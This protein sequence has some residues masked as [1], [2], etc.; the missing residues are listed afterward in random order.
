MKKRA[1]LA[2][3]S[4]VDDAVESLRTIIHKVHQLVVFRGVLRDPVVAP[5]LD[6]LDGI[7]GDRLHSTKVVRRV[8]WSYS[9]FFVGLAAQAGSGREMAV[10][11]PWQDHLLNVILRDENPFSRGSE[12]HGLNCLG[13]SLI[14]QV[15][16]DLERLRALFSLR[17]EQVQ[18]L[19]QAIGWDTHWPNWDRLQQRETSPGEILTHRLQIKRRLQEASD[20]EPLVPELATFYAQNGTGMFAEFRAFHWKPGSSAGVLQ[21]IS[22]PDPIRMEDLVGYE[23]QKLW[24]IRNTS[25]FLAGHPANNIFLYGDRGTGKSSSIKALLNHFTNRRLRMVEVSRDDLNDLPE[26][27][28]LLRERQQ[29]FI[30]F[31]DDLSFEEGETQYKTLKAVLEGSLESRPQNVVVYATSN[32]RHLIREFFSDRNDLRGDEIRHQDTLQEKVS[33]A[34]RFGIQLSFV[35]PDQKQYLEII[36]SMSR[37]RG[38]TLSPRDL[39]RRALEW[40][41]LYNARSGRTARQ[42]TDCLCAELET[43]TEEDRPQ[44]SGPR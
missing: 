23:D 30:L 20:W 2:L 15:E 39:E 32:R 1:G 29:H 43:G 7:A 31:V 6:F 3:D 40:A 18:A 10:G 11:T 36:H 4:E 33:L 8:A 9:S 21:G 24:L 16:A 22:S 19:F 37:K 38:L 17:S 27:M 12:R 13:S 41:Q 42:F 5:L 26:V 28:S 25:Y 14:L 34:D 44:G 35:A